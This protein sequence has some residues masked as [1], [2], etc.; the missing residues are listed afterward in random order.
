VSANSS[1]E[2]TERTW[3]PVTGCTEVSPGCNHC[4]AKTFAER[5]RGVVDKKTGKP[6]PFFNGFNITLHPERLRDP[7]RWRKPGQRVFVNSMSDLFHRDIPDRFIRRVFDVMYD[8][9]HCPHRHTFQVLT[10]RPERMRRLVASIFADWDARLVP[11]SR[12]Y[13]PDGIWLGVS[14]ESDA[15]AWR[16]E[17]LRETPAAIRWISFEPLLA[18][19][20][21]VDLTGIDWVV[22]GGESGHGAR[23]M[24]LG[25]VREIIANARAAG[26]AVFVKQLGAVWARKDHDA[27]R[28]PK[29]GDMV[30]WPTDLRV[31]EY[32]RVGAAS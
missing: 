16:A 29:G 11:S 18:S 7:L 28:D 32:P 27:R 3:N 1:I 30:F 13:K 21:K 10:K 17:M 14:I 15:F 8:G 26:A 12:P 31:R 20:A 23:P 6:H 25:W 4:Y 24:D 5:W 22:I 9:A 2:W 19:C